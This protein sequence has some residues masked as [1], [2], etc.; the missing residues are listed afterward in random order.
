MVSNKWLTL[1]YNSFVANNLKVNLYG[2]SNQCDPVKGNS[3]LIYN[4]M[5]SPAIL[6]TC[7]DT[8]ELKYIEESARYDRKN[9]MSSN[10]LTTG[11]IKDKIG[12]MV[13]SYVN[14]CYHNNTQIDVNKLCSDAFCEG[15]PC[16]T[17]KFNYNGQKEVYKVCADTPVI[18]IDNIKDQ[19]M[20][21][22]QQFTIKMVSQ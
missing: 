3:R 13:G 11:Q 12:N 14:I 15:K 5:K 2:D 10:F 9:N 18:C 21:N 20:F 7:S 6:G 22:S 17:V 16:T 4:Y 1:I 19:R 8:I